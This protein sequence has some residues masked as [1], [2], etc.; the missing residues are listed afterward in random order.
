M[1]SGPL[2]YPRSMNI[3]K[4]LAFPPFYIALLII[5]VLALHDAWTYARGRTDGTCR[6]DL[7][8]ERD[9]TG[10]PPGSPFS[11][12]VLPHNQRAASWESHSHIT[13]THTRNVHAH[14]QVRHGQTLS[15]RAWG[16]YDK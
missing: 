1:D 12:F 11:P 14:A 5:N 16:R 2:I 15:T 7:R 3:S 8:R 9:E 13:Y 10:L 4:R 6:S